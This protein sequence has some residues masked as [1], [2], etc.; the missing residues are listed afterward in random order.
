MTRG[1]KM[2]ERKGSVVMIEGIQGSGKSTTAKGLANLVG[3]ASERGI[4]TGGDLFANKEVDNWLGSLSVLIASCSDG[5]VVLDRCFLSLLAYN[6]RKKPRERELLYR[7][8][9]PLFRRRMDIDKNLI[10]F[11]DID[12]EV[13]HE[14][15]DGCGMHSINSLEDS[16]KEAEV[17]R[18]LMS[19]LEDDGYRVLRI[20]QGSIDEVM[21]MILEELN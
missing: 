16:Q 8:G 2:V 19:K 9:E 4:P 1:V 21:G 13:C 7:I 12:P 15:E 5:D 18:W 14:R 6:I 10:V 3:V 11:L 20:T 17:Y